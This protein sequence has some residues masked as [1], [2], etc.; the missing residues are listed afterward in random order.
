MSII[1]KDFYKVYNNL[2]N[3]IV[4][5]RVLYSF[6][7]NSLDPFE[8]MKYLDKEKAIRSIKYN[9]DSINNLKN[10]IKDLEEA[11]KEMN[12]FLGGNNE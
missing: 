8:D 11:Y 2:N 6:S 12:I 4:N 9:I 7:L 1:D 3:K 10:N 5:F